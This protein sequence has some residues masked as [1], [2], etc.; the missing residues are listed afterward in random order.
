MSTLLQDLRYGVRVLRM[1]PGFTLVA[2]LA[3]AL[4]IGANT[5]IFSIVNALLVRPLPF[6]NLDRMV[7]IWEKIPSRNVDRNETAAANYFDW[8][9][10]NQVFEHLGAYRWWSVNL[11]GVD[12]PERVQGYQV[13]ASF[14]DMLGV[15]PADGRGFSPEEERPGQNQVAVL[16][17]G[18]WQ[19]RF[20]G[21]PQIIGKTISLN[22]VPYT[23]VGVMP[24]EFNFP[25][26][27][28][29]LAP[30]A[31][32]P[33]QSQN[34][35]D[36]Y[37]LTVGRLR[38]GVTLERAQAEMDTIARRLEQQYPR[39]NTGTGVALFPLRSDSVRFYEPALLV[40]FGA[41][42][43]VLLM[44]CANVANLMLARA[45]SR[46]KEIAIRAALGAGRL[47]IVRQLLTESLTLA[48][49]GG[50]LGI[51]L[52]L[53]GTD[54]IRAMIP[55]EFAPFIY[56][57]KQI[58]LDLRVLGFTLGLSLLTGLVFGLVPALQASKPD[59]NTALK[60]GSRTS[61]VFSRRRLR[62][63]LVVS[64]VAI[65]FVLLIGAGLMMKSFAHLMTTDPGFNTES[66]LT[67]ELGLPAAKYREAAPRV[68]F[69]EQ[70]LQRIE[71]L[72]GVE[73]AGA[74]NHL[75]LGGSNS[76]I[77]L[78]IEGAPE[79]PPGQGIGGRYRVCSPRYFQALG[80]TLLAGRGFTDQDTAD[81]P[82]VVII[83]ETM[84]RRFW[85]KEEPIGKRIR[86]PGNPERNP[87]MQ[88]VGVV[89]DVKHELNLAVTPE[90]YR[91]YAQDA[92][93]EMNLVARTRT[94]PMALA[95]AIRSQVLALDN[96]Q[97]VFR[98]RTLEQVRSES[99]LFQRFSVVILGLFG[100]LALILVAA[101]I[102]GVMSY[103]VAQRAHEIGIRLALGAQARDVLR[104]VVGQGLGLTSIGVAIGVAAAF[105]LTRLM[106]RLLFEVS[107]TDPSVFLVIAL[108]LAA[109]A[110]VACYLPARRAM[111]VDPMVALRYE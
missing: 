50:A 88:V 92:W 39:T 45:S 48:F 43:C 78:L 62:S 42:G 86:F 32:T 41:V 44:A 83:N 104:L 89:R 55:A 6:E 10:Q 20:A 109:V 97:P 71:A 111:K 102:Y 30:L 107:A 24:P 100:T 22:S 49:I 84:A 61:A 21:D 26:G 110:L 73:A 108:L 1:K 2:I 12:A 87:W 31:L 3:L 27:G 34:R 103:S 93:R 7:A 40:L 4:G 74:V 35:G 51:L 8:R 82:L 67:M 11:T 16:H 72:P 95:A 91:P 65:S 101:G 13:T 79:P 68:A 46:D 69:F 33:E 54:W 59:L 17:H 56:G 5:A 47:R 63:L 28:E 58:G 14:F 53:W 94:E 19:R 99:V 57:W 90:F 37:L 98:I 52:A 18:F 29:V 96:D 106:E 15:R 70:L 9:A 76:S 36:H 23:V 66:A 85:P 25:K 81:A 80:M 75:P 105:G 64:E 77:G 38:P 60:E